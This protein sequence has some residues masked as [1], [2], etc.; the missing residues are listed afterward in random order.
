MSYDENARRPV[1]GTRWVWEPQ[2]APELIEVTETLW[3]GEEW[4][5]RTH[6]IWEARAPKGVRSPGYLN[7]LGRFWEAV[8]AIVERPGPTH[9]ASI[10]QGPPR[11][12]EIRDE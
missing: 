2:S 7:D 9:G 6:G 8:H 10:T 1:V 4:W 11:P 5:V 3:N 12:E